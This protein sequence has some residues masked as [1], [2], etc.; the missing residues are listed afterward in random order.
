MPNHSFST[1]VSQ[2]Q[3]ENIVDPWTTW[4][5]VTN[6]RAVENSHITFDLQKQLLSTL[7]IHRFNQLQLGNYSRKCENTVFSAGLIESTD[8]KPA[9]SRCHCY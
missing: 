2:A 1:A 8:T 3:I 5:L 4:G 9:D 6:P 7:C